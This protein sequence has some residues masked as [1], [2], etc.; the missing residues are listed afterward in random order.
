M[1]E[2]LTRDV[3]GGWLRPSIIRNVADLRLL[4][5]TFM[6]VELRANPNET[7]FPK[8]FAPPHSITALCATPL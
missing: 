2:V 8:G 6:G 4:D 3:T 7:G 1:A 5:S